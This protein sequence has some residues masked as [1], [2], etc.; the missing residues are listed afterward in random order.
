MAGLIKKI[1]RAAVAQP[2]EYQGEGAPDEW[3]FRVSPDE[4]SFAVWDP[5]YDRWLIYDRARPDR[6]MAEAKLNEMNRHT[7]DWAQYVEQLE[8]E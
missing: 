5:G 8:D 7:E 1:L 3:E 2:W 6:I 4:G